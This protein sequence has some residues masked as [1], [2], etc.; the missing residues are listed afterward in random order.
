M[1]VAEGTFYLEAIPANGVAVRAA[2]N[3]RNVIASRSHAPTEITSNRTRCH[4][5]GP[6]LA[7]SAGKVFASKSQHVGR[8]RASPR[9]ALPLLAVDGALRLL[10]RSSDAAKHDLAVAAADAD[11]AAARDGADLLLQ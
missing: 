3:E 9:G 6:H 1:K 2:R 11:A 10:P 5:R 4:D 7:L 8:V